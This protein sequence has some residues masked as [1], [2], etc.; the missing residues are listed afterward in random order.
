[1]IGGAHVL[2]IVAILLVAATVRSTE[3]YTDRY[4]T[5]PMLDWVESRQPL[6]E[7]SDIPSAVDL[8]R[9]VTRALPLLVIRDDARTQMPV[10]GPPSSVERVMGGVR[11]AA[12][13]SLGSPGDYPAGQ[14]PIT[15][16]L[17]VIVFNRELRASDWSALF[18]RAM[19]IRDP[20]SG[21]PQVRVEGPV[22]QDMVWVAQPDPVR[23]QGGVSTVV[24]HRGPIGFVLQ[25][26]LLHDYVQ[27]DA[28]QLVDL[29]ARAEVI[30]RQAASDW[31]AWATSQTAA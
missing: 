13:I 26:N 3:L 10:F 23:G 28:A 22:A 25:V 8:A 12:R 11:D 6:A 20:D 31:S 18:G 29:S 30:A 21:L 24:G 9:G 16:R 27:N 2:A 4:Q 15:V 14:L 5:L 17:D 19:D 7:A 1:M